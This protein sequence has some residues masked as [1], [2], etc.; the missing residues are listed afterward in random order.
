EDLILSH[1]FVE[2]GML[3]RAGWGVRFLPRA[4]GS[5]EETPQ[6]VID[7]C[8]RDR[9]WCKG[10]LQ[11]LRLLT[12]KGFHPVSRFHLL[13]GAFAFL[14]SPAWFALL[15]VWSLV[16]TMSDNSASYFTPLNPLYPVWPEQAPFGGS[17]FLFFIYGMLLLP[18]VLGAFALGL[19]R[20]I[21]EAYGGWGRFVGATVFEIF[22]SI[23]YAPIM[24]VQQT[25][26]V[27]LALTGKSDNWTPQN[28]G[29]G[30]YSWRQ[31]LRF[32]VLEVVLGTFIAY[33][34]ATGSLSL[35]LVPIA[36][37]LVLA[38]I[39]SKL[40]AVNVSDLPMSFLR[41]NSPHDL[42]EPRIVTLARSKR[43]IMASELTK[44]PVAAE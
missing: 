28:R 18:K 14:M 3:R 40:S 9:R 32:H 37:S 42:R 1:D 33:G 13:Q 17:L 22:C 16:G 39:L 11:H 10:N 26:A 35:W 34:V 23:L 19:R 4:S 31:V 27:V 25:I 5:F 43:M 12:V 2:A 29:H 24:M 15:I 21:R 41:L 38:P 36:F 7:Y 8:L 6:T 20:R 44:T 30:G